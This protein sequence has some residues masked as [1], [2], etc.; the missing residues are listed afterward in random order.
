MRAVPLTTRLYV[1]RLPRVES[2]PAYLC[3]LLVDV[4]HYQP[5]PA[6]SRSLSLFRSR[7]E[8]IDKGQFGQPGPHESSHT[9][10]YVSTAAYNSKSW[11]VC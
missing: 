11:G 10:G 1:A 7:L 4:E 9:G 6:A 5:R 2:R 8:F 3:Q